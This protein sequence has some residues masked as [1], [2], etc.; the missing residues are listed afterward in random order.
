MTI[1][2]RVVSS[3]TS[4]QIGV[5]FDVLEVNPSKVSNHFIYL[6]NGTL[7]KHVGLTFVLRNLIRIL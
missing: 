3:R 1:E 7:R 2:L 4:I 6:I 5:F